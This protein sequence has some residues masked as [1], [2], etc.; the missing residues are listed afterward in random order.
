MRLPSLLTGLALVAALP[1]GCLSI[2]KKHLGSPYLVSRSQGLQ[3]GQ[4]KSEVLSALGAP[5]GIE[6]DSTN[7]ARELYIY[8]SRESEQRT[9]FFPPLLVLWKK[10][11][12]NKYDERR[13]TVAFENNRIVDLKYE[14]WGETKLDRAS[15]GPKG[16]LP[17]VPVP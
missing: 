2:E 7:L 12:Y 14:V 3:K 4:T 17:S 13:L 16:K 15:D 8:K 10:T 6:P 9:R 1:S 11:Y 5:W